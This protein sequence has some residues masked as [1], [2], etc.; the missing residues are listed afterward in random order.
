MRPL[1]I[2]HA[3]CSDGFG[4]AWVF[5]KF[6]KGEVD[7]HY[8]K[9]GTTPPSI[10]GADVYIV[11]FCYDR[12]DMLLIEALSKSLV[13]LDHH[14]SAQKRCG[15]LSFCT[16][17]MNRSGAMMAWDYCFPGQRAPALIH[18][19]QDRDLWKWNLYETAAVC[20]YIDTFPWVFKEWDKLEQ[21]LEETTDYVVNTGRG[22]LKFSELQVKMLAKRKFILNIGG[23]EVPTVNTATFRSEVCDVLLNETSPVSATYS[24]NGEKYTFSVRSDG[25][26]DVSELAGKYPGGG[27]HKN[28]AGFSIDRLED[29]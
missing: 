25:R 29:L 8:A 9:H 23:H 24:F 18:Y 3:D 4:A 6:F 11:D 15:D 10:I 14:A 26:V 13:V 2:V 22:I 1:V 21:Q 7:F 20:S 12:N 27:G 28:A 5:N 16:F 17:D 19:I